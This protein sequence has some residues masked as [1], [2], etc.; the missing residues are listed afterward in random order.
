MAWRYS[1]AA[2]SRLPWSYKTIAE[3]VAAKDVLG[4]DAEGRAVLGGRLV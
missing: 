3:A 4:V 1:A 2:S